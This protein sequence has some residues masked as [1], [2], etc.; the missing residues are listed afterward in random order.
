MRVAACEWMH[1]LAAR[2]IR[3]CPHALYV[4]MHVLYVCTHVPG[5][6]RR[7]W[8]L[9]LCAMLGIAVASCQRMPRPT[10]PPSG[11]PEPRFLPP[12]T[13]PPTPPA[14]GTAAPSA[15]QR[16][17]FTAAETLRNSGQYIQARQAFA[18]FVRHYPASGLTDAALLALGHI[19]ATLEQYAQAVTYY[20]ALLD[21]F[22]R[23]A[24]VPE[25]HLGLG[26]ALYH[27]QD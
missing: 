22:P 12:L 27:T 15:E 17:A 13:A 23:S 18:D 4:C 7:L 20:R 26:V 19:S 1:C 5:G 11:P 9:L 14:V 6:L 3:S 16:A 2:S 8:M 24:R 25:A 10:P 21:R